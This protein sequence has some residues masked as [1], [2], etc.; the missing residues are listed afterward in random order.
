MKILFDHQI[1]TRKIHGGVSRYFYELISNL[2]NFQNY[3]AE[4]SL[5]LSNNHFISNKTIT[6]H[7]D[8][9]SNKK[10]WKQKKIFSYINRLNSILK[11]K[12]QN[13]DI[14][15]PTY[16]DTY[17]LEYIGKKP[18][19]LTVYDMIHEKFSDLF[20]NS[21]MTRFKKKLLIEKASK[22]IAISKNTKKDLIDILGVKE[23]KI[24]V[25]YLGNS[26]THISQDTKNL[27]LP[28]KFLLYVGKREGY[29]NFNRFVKSIASIFKTHEELFFLCVG[30]GKF[31]NKENF[32]L[33]SLGVNNKI[34]HQEMNDVELNFCY[35]N[36]IALCYPS[37]YEGFGIPLLEAFSNGCP[38]I[39]SNTSSLPEV[40]GEAACYFDP[41]DEQSIK[42]S[43][44]KI[45]DDNL[46]RKLT[47]EGHRQLKNFT[48]KKTAYETKK[49]YDN[50]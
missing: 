2:N 47:Y 8:I 13:F 32:F 42:K 46:R 25:V 40:A 41:Y 16:Y 29:K 50:L 48:W 22:I 6:K 36:S 19:V 20:A 3:E 34:L 7:L 1:F 37:L 30:G 11:L 28:K 17:F 31:T 26:L 5:L 12:Q 43:V 9:F 18:F 21:D 10:I 45:L 15:H 24:E 23:S 39:C 4:V 33:S 14:F 35:K 27:K 49:I 38:V 44:L